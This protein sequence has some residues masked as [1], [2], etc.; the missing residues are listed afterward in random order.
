[1]NPQNRNL[2]EADNLDIDDIQIEIEK[3]VSNIGKEGGENECL[4][5]QVFCN[6][7]CDIDSES[8]RTE[9]N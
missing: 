9:T 7:S 1:M 3:P 2:G 4:A 6:S 5:K 8:V